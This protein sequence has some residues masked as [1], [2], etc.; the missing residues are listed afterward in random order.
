MVED[1]II[2]PVA[3]AYDK[4]LER[5]FVRHELMVG[6]VLLSP[7]PL[8]LTHAHSHTFSRAGWI[9]EARDGDAGDQRCL[10]HAYKEHWL[11]EGGLCSTFFTAGTYMYVHHMKEDSIA[12]YLC[13]SCNKRFGKAFVQMFKYPVAPFLGGC[14]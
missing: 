5:R 2:V 3:I 4:L 11:C 13:F 12:L 8:S 10:G 6:V 1:I 7:P 14:L 9:Q